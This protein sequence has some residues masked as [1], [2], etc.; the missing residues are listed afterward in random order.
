MSPSVRVQ[1]LTTART[2]D[3]ALAL[4]GVGAAAGVVVGLL[5]LRGTSPLFGEGSIGQ[6]AALSAAGTSL[7][8]AAGVLWVLTP[9]TQPWL[10]RLHPLHR[11][12]TVFG[13][14]VLHAALAL[15]VTSALF[16]VFQ[17]AFRGV[18]LDPMASTFWVAAA[19]AAAA[20]LT[21][22]SAAEMTTRSLSSLLVMFAVTGALA[23]ALLAPDPRWWESYFSILGTGTGGSRVAFNLTLLLTGLVLVTVGEFLAHDLAV[24]ADA[25]G[26]RRWKVH[27]VRWTLLL[28]GVLIVAVGLITVDR[29]KAWHDGAAHALI[30]VFV[31][32]LLGF[33]VL[34]RRLARSFL[35]VT[36]ATLLTIAVALWLWEGVGYL[37]TTAFEMA[38]GV[39][40]FAWL[41]LFIRTVTA[42]AQQVQ[43]P[44]AAP[45]T[46]SNA[47][48]RHLSPAGSATTD[49]ARARTDDGTMG[50]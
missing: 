35:V 30:L 39:T 19:S 44:S 38:A 46:A 34:F 17:Q 16:A 18:A 1:P 29:A 12:W 15:M 26:E 27:V 21:A 28:L 3:T 41:L 33:P 32:A 4:A 8:V 2:E 7:L 22:S 36:M 9:R 40:V 24:W 42:A 31:V 43:A 6:A 49:P 20:Y 10:R 5:T 11:G 45:L 14:A 37:N 50:A 25:T 48:P 23:A 47:T 13:L